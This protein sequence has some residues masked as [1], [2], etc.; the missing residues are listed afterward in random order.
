MG[1]K[2]AGELLCN[3]TGNLSHSVSTRSG[4]V[5]EG[6]ATVRRIVVVVTVAVW[7]GF[8]I[9]ER[10]VVRVHLEFDMDVDERDVGYDGGVSTTFRSIERNIR[11]DFGF[12]LAEA[13]VSMAMG[14]HEIEVRTVGL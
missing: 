10:V 14:V 5:L 2:L 8:R 6:E 1:A 4:V 3:I 13:R 11:F 7:G 12:V 9:T